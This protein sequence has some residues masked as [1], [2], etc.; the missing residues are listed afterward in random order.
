MSV[1]KIKHVNNV[2]SKVGKDK[3]ILLNDLISKAGVKQDEMKT[4]ISKGYIKGLCKIDFGDRDDFIEL[5]AS[6]LLRDNIVSSE[7]VTVAHND[8]KEEEANVDPMSYL[9]TDV[10]IKLIKSTTKIIK[11][12]KVL[13]LDGVLAI[14]KYNDMEV[15]NCLDDNFKVEVLEYIELINS[16]RKFIKPKIADRIITDLIVNEYKEALK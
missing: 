7:V 13:T 3:K 8:T 1:T 4:Y 11:R 10:R 5:V 14:L 2:I 9:N 6:V 16:I 15:V 12:L